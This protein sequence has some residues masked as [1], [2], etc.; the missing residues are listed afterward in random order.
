MSDSKKVRE[1]SLGLLDEEEQIPGG[2]RYFVKGSVHQLAGDLKDVAG[3]LSHGHA[4]QL[5]SLTLFTLLLLIVLVKVSR[6]PGSQEHIKEDKIYQDLTQL[7]AGIESLCHPC[8]WDWTFFQGNCYF[9]SEIQHN[10]HNSVTACQEMGAQ[11]VVIKSE[12]EQR[13]LQQASKSKGRTWMGLSD[14]KHEGT[15]H[16]VDG[17]HLM[18]RFMKYWNEGEPN[19]SGDE[20]CAEFRGDGWNDVQFPSLLETGTFYVTRLIQNLGISCFSIPCAGITGI[21]YQF[22]PLLFFL[23]LI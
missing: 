5:L 1:P 15:W 3:G 22:S 6:F 16:W 19:S 20:D 13:F 12:E 4:L 17:S 18:F 23:L 2:T 10:W 9:F 21:H 8:Q 7:K 11:L 14:L